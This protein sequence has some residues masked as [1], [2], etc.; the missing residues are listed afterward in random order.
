M[1]GGVGS[2]GGTILGALII[3][4]L[5]NGMNIVGV[6]PYFQNIIKGLVLILSVFVTIDR[7]KIGV[8]K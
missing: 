4:I 1:T 6:D 7:K 2:V 8:I 3:T 5:S